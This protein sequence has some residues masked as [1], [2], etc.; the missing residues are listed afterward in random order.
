[1]ARGQSV[2]GYDP[3]IWTTPLHAASRVGD[4]RAVLALLEASADPT[5]S[6]PFG[7]TPLHVAAGGRHAAVV[8]ALLAA[9]AD[10]SAAT[11]AYAHGATPLHY[12]T[13]RERDHDAPLC[14][15]VVGRLLAS[16]ADPNA[17]DLADRTPLHHAAG[18]ARGAASAVR[19]LLAAG[20]DPMLTDWR[21]MTPLHYATRFGGGGQ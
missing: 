13:R 8:G 12:A 3:L 7:Q 18:G 2:E 16:G 14:A 1:M 17:R 9:G 20:A 5:L 21:G 19:A 6:D 11:G 10:P 4:L 15:D